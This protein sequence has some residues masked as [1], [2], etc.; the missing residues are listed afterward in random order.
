MNLQSWVE[1]L[2]NAA[3]SPEIIQLHIRDTVA[4]FLAGSRTNDGRALMQLHRDGTKE[5]AVAAIARLSECDDIHLASCITPGSAVIPVALAFAKDNPELQRAISAGYAAG[6]GLGRAIGGV[7]ALAHGVWP[8]L[9]AAPLMAAV[10]ASLLRGHDR[11]RFAYAVALAL[12]G[13]NGRIGRPQGNPS[14][15]WFYFADA[16]ARGMR[17]AEA[18]GQGLCGDLS[19]VSEE[20]LASQAGHDDTD[21]GALE[22]A[23][24]IVQVGFKPFPIARQGANAVVAF[25]RLLSRGLDPRRIDRVEV[26]VPGVNTAL[27]KRPIAAE[28][29]LSRIANVGYQLACA[30]LAPERLYDAERAGPHETLMEFAERVSVITANDL[31]SAMPHRWPARVTAVAGSD[32]FEE[33]IIDAPFDWDA[34]NLPALLREKWQKLLNPED[35]ALI[36]GA[37]S[38]YSELWQVLERR[39]TMASNEKLEG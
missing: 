13:A 17:A 33:T 35:A 32:R 23:P 26:S 36:A 19:L 34:S 28:D 10:T 1:L 18:A 12:A 3:A 4:A 20:W 29:R 15:R 38:S 5:P 25:Q 7:K 31:E 11:E 27:L 24:S 2:W 30:A 22:S 16:V 37:S 39:V 9:L 8:T 6:M 21:M 14:E